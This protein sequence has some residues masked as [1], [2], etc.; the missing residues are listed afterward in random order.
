[1]Y[2]VFGYDDMC[3]DFDYK[4]D[5]FVSAMKAFKSLD[6]SGMC[7]VFMMRETPGSCLHVK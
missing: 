5:S 6:S 2:S 3:I 1:M 7:V 4:F